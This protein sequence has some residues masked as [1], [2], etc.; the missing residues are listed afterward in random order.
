MSYD[1]Y[2]LQTMEN[3]KKWLAEAAH[4]NWLC[5]FCHDADTPTGYIR[6]REGKY[7]LEPA[8]FV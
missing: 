4:G 7:T 1:L 8:P 5:V 6:E 2:P 3:K